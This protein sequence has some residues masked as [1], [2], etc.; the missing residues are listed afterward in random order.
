MNIP[1]RYANGF[2]G[3]IGVP[4][5]PAPMDYNAWFEVFLDGRWFTFDARHNMPRI[6]R[7]TVA[8]GRDATD[9]P[10]ATSFG[11]HILK[12]FRVWT[13]EA[14]PTVL[15]GLTRRIA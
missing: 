3:D 14:G 15:S 13:E 10:L 9:I 1:A 2:L 8:R 5:D 7:I 4:P 12:S 11:P 6:G